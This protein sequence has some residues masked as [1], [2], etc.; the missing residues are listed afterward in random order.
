MRER[1]QETIKD[2]QMVEY[3]PGVCSPLK[4]FLVYFTV[5]NTIV[6]EPLTDWFFLFIL[7]ILLSICN[8]PNQYKFSVP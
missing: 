6:Y 8:L 5:C 2:G 4:D 1:K 7:I 3:L